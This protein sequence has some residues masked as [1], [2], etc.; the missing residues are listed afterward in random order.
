MGSLS[1]TR[2]LFPQAKQKGRA[3]HGRWVQ[4]GRMRTEHTPARSLPE[5]TLSCE[6]H[7]ACLTGPDR[8]SVLPLVEG[9]HIGRGVEGLQDSQVP[10]LLAVVTRQGEPSLPKQGGSLLERIKKGRS[11][12]LAVAYLR[13]GEGKHFQ[14][15]APDLYPVYLGQKLQFGSSVWQVRR[16]PTQLA[17]PHKVKKTGRGAW[18]RVTTFIM[19]VMLLFLLARMLPDAR[20]LYLLLSGVAVAALTVLIARRVGAR[21]WDPSHLVHCAFASAPADSESEGGARPRASVEKE[22][23][24]V[25]LEPGKPKK[26]TLDGQVLG[27]VGP[28]ARGY[29]HWLAAQVLA[30]GRHAHVLSP[31]RPVAKESLGE[32]FYV[33]WAGSSAE[34]PSFV[35]RVMAARPAAGGG[36][37]DLIGSMVDG[38]QSLPETV[39]FE[40]LLGPPKSADIQARWESPTWRAPI[41]LDKDGRVFLDL[42][43]D[44]PHALVAGGTGSGKSEFLTTFILSLAASVPASQLRFVFIDYKGGAGLEHLADLPHVEQSLTDLDG[45]QTPWLLRTLGAALRVRKEG[46][47]TLGFRSWE[48]WDEAS[49]SEASVALPPPPPPPRLVIVVDE[50]RVLSDAHPNL[51]AELTDITTQGRSLGMH[52]L[53]ATQRPG[54]AVTPNMR[55]TLDLRFALRCAEAAD[56]VETIGDARAADLPRTPG[57]AIFEKTH[58]QTAWAQNPRKWVE[59]IK[60]A[61]N[62]NPTQFLGSYPPQIASPLPDHLPH[63]GDLESGALGD[64]LGVAENPSTARLQPVTYPEGPL[65]ILGPP[66]HRAQLHALALSAAL[67]KSP[68]ATVNIADAF[69]KLWV[70]DFPKGNDQSLRSWF[71]EVIPTGDLGRAAQILTSV[72]DGDLGGLTLVIADAS[73][74]LRRLENQVGPDKVRPLV[75]QI[76][77]SSAPGLRLIVTDTRPSPEV[78]EIGSRMFRLPSR[79]ALSRP[80]LLSLLPPISEGTNASSALSRFTS[81]NSSRVLFASETRA[82]SWMQVCSPPSNAPKALAQEALAPKDFA[83]ASPNR[84]EQLV[85]IAPNHLHPELKDFLQK[86]SLANE[87][88][89]LAPHEWPKL[90]AYPECE[91]LAVEPNRETLRHFAG[92]HPSESLWILASHPLPRGHAIYAANGLATRVSLEMGAR[93]HAA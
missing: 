79:A 82:P 89:F 60:R 64:R 58:V 91:V 93:P 76:I 70:G 44:G 19:P 87:A 51:M 22:R 24:M 92:L 62:E 83:A 78:G 12:R 46:A 14:E 25:L 16:R 18:L 71:S 69:P 33:A 52:L 36:W 4:N 72:A 35:S 84:Q 15:G 7:L 88:V 56:S 57:R 39:L 74:L 41:G 85:V 32:G 29:A 1:Q 59:A 9:Q 61:T 20:W 42:V 31:D 17:W 21:R 40:S 77:A 55:A 49:R 13:P 90:S 2:Q 43:R 75:Q 23:L 54:G 34:L 30:A 65:A 45:G 38:S 28:E 63:P 68:G 5:R 10:A 37:T 80:E 6:H 81:E 67:I 3:P 47:A 50:F 11:D 48:E 53:I 73:D 26:L 8:G 66:S 86:D 27:V